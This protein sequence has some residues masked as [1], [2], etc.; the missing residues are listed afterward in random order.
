MKLQKKIALA[1]LALFI[2]YS[3]SSLESFAF[4]ESIDWM[5]SLFSFNITLAYNNYFGQGL[6]NFHNILAPYKTYTTPRIVIGP[7]KN[8]ILIA[9][10]KMAPLYLGNIPQS[11]DH[12]IDLRQAAG[13]YD[14]NALIALHTLNRDFEQWLVSL[15]KSI[16]KDD[17]IIQYHY[18]TTDFTAPSRIDLIRGI[19]NLKERDNRGEK[20]AYVHCKAGKGRSA[21]L[22]VAYLLYVYVIA[23]KVNPNGSP[24][25][26][27]DLTPDELIDAMICYLK[28]QRYLV[29][30]NKN[31]RSALVELYAELIKYGSF[32]AV[33][34]HYQERIKKRNAEF[35]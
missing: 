4:R 16:T 6:C 29:N 2:L 30:I 20:I 14:N 15:N 27:K 7:C 11:P 25:T 23:D 24:Y 28:T 9:D 12:F 8:I 18:S 17:N 5:K 3:G 13:F 19:Y 32:D 33:Y 10:G 35:K 21:T 26:G 22:I 34:A 31:Q 1:M